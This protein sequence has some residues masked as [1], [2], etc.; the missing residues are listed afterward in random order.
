MEIQITANVW[1]RFKAK[2]VGDRAF[3][4]MTLLL[5]IP[6]IIQNTVTNLDSAPNSVEIEND[7]S[8]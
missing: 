8:K 6:V 1:Q 5:V 2:F 3:Y 4:K 7:G